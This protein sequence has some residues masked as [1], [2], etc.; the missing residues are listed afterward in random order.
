MTWLRSV[1]KPP[2]RAIRARLP[3]WV[4]AVLALA[5]LAGVTGLAFA[6]WSSV[7]VASGASITSGDLRVTLGALTWE[8]PDQNAS[9]DGTD[10]ATLSIA[11][12]ET[13]I[14]RQPVTVEA[15]GDNMRVALS[16]ALP[17]LPAGAAGDWHIEADDA[18]VVPPSGEASL[19]DSLVLPGA[20][21][22][23]TDWVVVVNLDMPSGE[24][25]WTDPTSQPSPSAPALDLGAMTVRASQVRCGEGFSVACPGGAR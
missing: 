24:P 7:A 10:L 8:C 3:K 14:L 12:G 18:Q 9:G 20:R 16:V 17:G 19:A 6:W 4:G 22:D 21:A 13:L 15:A 5:S 2:R 1:R 25:V 11:P 23:V